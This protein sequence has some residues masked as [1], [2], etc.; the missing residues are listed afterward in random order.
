MK[1]ITRSVA[2]LEFVLEWAFRKL[3]EWLLETLLKP[4]GLYRPTSSYGLRVKV[5]S[6]PSRVVSSPSQGGYPSLEGHV[7]QLPF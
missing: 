3:F 6:A 7:I 4:K 5:T 2:V 1:W